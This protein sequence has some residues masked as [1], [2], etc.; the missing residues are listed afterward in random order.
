M[1]IL[2]KQVGFSRDEVLAMSVAEV[3]SHLT[4]LKERLGQRSSG[5]SETKRYVSARR[6]KRDGQ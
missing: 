3:D 6:R 4:L 1:Q 5:T 2:V